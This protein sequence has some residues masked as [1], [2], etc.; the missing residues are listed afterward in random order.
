[1]ID[2]Y[3]QSNVLRDIPLIDFLASEEFAICTSDSKEKLDSI[4]IN[5]YRNG[6]LTSVKPCADAL[7]HIISSTVIPIEASCGSSRKVE[8]HSWIESIET[9]SHF[10]GGVNFSRYLLCSIIR[11]KYLQ[12]A[13]ESTYRGEK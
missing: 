10:L 12:R 11:R 4:A 1:M 8:K 9:I 3:V 5:Q 13:L 7:E 2:R 6:A